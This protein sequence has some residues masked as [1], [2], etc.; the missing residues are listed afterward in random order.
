MGQQEARG[1]SDA[2]SS[3]QR[4][5]LIGDSIT[6]CDRR[7]AGYPLGGGY[8]RYFVDKFVAN[9]PDLDVDFINKGISGNTTRHLRERWEDDVIAIRPDWLSIMVGINDC[10][11]TVWNTPEAVPADEFRVIYDELLARTRS[12]LDC[13][14]VLI[15]PFYISRDFSGTGERSRILGLLPGYLD[16]VEE[17]SAKHGTLLVK[18]HELFQKQLDFRHPDC[19]CPEPVHPN[20]TG[21]VLIAEWLYNALSSAGAV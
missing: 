20:M 1:L 7:G 13:R 19:F 15:Q 5:V 8:V 9:H 21:H 11:R 4:F 16:A 18:T 17:L 10:H 12:A 2:I 14:I 6:D 3:G